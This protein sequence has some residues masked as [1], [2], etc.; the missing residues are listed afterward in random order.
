VAAPPYLPSVDLRRAGVVGLI[1]GLL[2]APLVGETQQARAPVI[3]FLSSASPSVSKEFMAAFQ[4]ALR[5]PGYIDGENVR[6]EYRW[7]D[8]HYDRLPSLATDLINRRATVI[9]AGG[10]PAALAVKAATSTIPIVFI[11]SEAVPLRLAT[12]LNR[13]GGNATGVSVLSISCGPSD[14][15]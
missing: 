7:A 14:S 8:G 1:L 11:V 3:G 2:A 9:A 15:N 5:E 6:I 13:P 4:H 10:P 12:S